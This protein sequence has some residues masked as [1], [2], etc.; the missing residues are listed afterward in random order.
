M[1][2][3]AL[4]IIATLGYAGFQFFSAKAG[5][6]IDGGLVPVIVNVCAVIV[7]LAFLLTRAANKAHFLPTQRSGLVYAILAGV[8]IA[9]FALAFHKIFQHGGNLSYISPLVF[10]G[11]IA[12]ASVLSIIFLKESLSLYH[13]I[14]T[15][16]V[17][18]GIVFISVAKAH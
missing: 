18:T 1:S 14:G 17:L 15:I 4:V 16:L 11:S 6:K 12:L 5:G 10:G 3:L 13:V 8:S 9:A 7:P 2:T